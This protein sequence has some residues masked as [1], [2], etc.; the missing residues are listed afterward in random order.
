[1]EGWRLAEIKRDDFAPNVGGMKSF[2]LARKKWQADRLTSIMKEA[3]CGEHW[4][5]NPKP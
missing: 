3:G 5:D 2:E 1:M 4:P